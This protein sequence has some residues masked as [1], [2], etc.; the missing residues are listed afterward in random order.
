MDYFL[1]IGN[2]TILIKDQDLVS[3]LVIVLNEMILSM[4]NP[5]AFISFVQVFIHNH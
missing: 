5:T 4:I 2:Y 3:E 1:F